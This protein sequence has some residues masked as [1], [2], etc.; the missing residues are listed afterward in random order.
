MCDR[1]NVVRT[2][3]ENLFPEKAA[4]ATTDD[5]HTL[6]E[7]MVNADV[8]IGLS[9]GN[10]VSPEMLL[11]MERNPIVFAMANPDPEIN[12]ALAKETRDDAILATGR[13]DTPNQVNNV[14][15]FPFVF[16][17]ALDCRAKKV[18]MEMKLAAAYALAELAKEDVPDR[19]LLAYNAE[20]IHFGPEY[21]IPK[22]FDPRVLLRVA[23]AVAAA[24]AASGV[25]RRPIEDLDAYE[26]HLHRLAERQ[27][28]APA[29]R[30]AQH[31][32][33]RRRI[34]FTDGE[35]H[36]VIRAA[37][38]LADTNVCTPILVGNPE[39][40]ESAAKERGLSLNGVTIEPHGASER[41]NALAEAYWSLRRRKGVTLEG[42]KALMADTAYFGAML[43]REGHADGL[44]GGP[45]RSYRHTV[46]PAL[47]ALGTEK[48]STRVSGVYVMLM[49]AALH[50]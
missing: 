26:E 35:N 44:V 13:S 41:S 48:K 38:Q 25:A 14:L 10:V 40:I 33:K 3:R 42:A 6:Q 16:R 22:P 17:G 45:S 36:R 23:P 32:R 5:V 39:V 7:A 47:Q 11:S 21:I 8:F 19:V 12:Y 46:R 28:Y 29:I 4:F 49:L 31:A 18:N 15:G 50:R 20:D 2:D 24:A 30:R 37:Q 27:P 43:V 34:A 1:R 9:V